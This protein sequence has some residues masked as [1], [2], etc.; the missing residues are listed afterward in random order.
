MLSDQW[1]NIMHRVLGNQCG[2][3]RFP[4]SAEQKPNP[5][6]WCDHCFEHLTPIKRCTRCGLKMTEKASQT[7]TECGECLK[8]PPPWQRLYTLGDYDLPLSHQVQRFKDN[9]ESWHVTALTQLLAERIEHPAPIIT[10]VPLHW[11][12]YLKRGFNQSH[13]LATHLAHHLNSNYRN[14]VFKRVKSAQSQRGNK[15]A[16]REQNLKAAFALHGEV[17]FSHIAIVDDVVTTGST[18]R[19][20]C[21]LLLEVGVESIDIYCICRTPAPGSG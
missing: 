3:C 2:L 6:R 11:Q 19:Q 1:Q 4:I 16:G 13:V 18:V 8:E 15:K 14:R 17:N 20:L 9:G 10:S 7:S 5:M 12:R 21:H